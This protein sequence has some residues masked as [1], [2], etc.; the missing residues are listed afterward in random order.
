MPTI[1]TV[2]PSEMTNTIPALADILIDCV[3]GGASVSFQLPLARDRS[4]AFWRGIGDAVEAGK[5]R[6][7]IAEHEGRIVGTV[8]VQFASFENQPHR[9]EI[10]KMLV[11]RSARRLGVG[12]ALML[13]AEDEA[14]RCGKTLLVLDTQSGSAG[15]KLYVKMGWTKVGTIPGYALTP[16]DGMCDTTIYYKQLA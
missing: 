10:A 1:R 5:T 13:A 2:T 3:E 8:Q 11:H 9:G 4:E 16:F 12:A 6:L 14:K 15:E 7:L